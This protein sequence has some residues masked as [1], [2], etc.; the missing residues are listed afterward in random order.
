MTVCSPAHLFK[1]QEFS[2][3]TKW[4]IYNLREIFTYYAN[5][6]QHGIKTTGDSRYNWNKGQFIFY[7]RTTFTLLLWRTFTPFFFLIF[8]GIH[9]WDPAWSD[10]LQRKKPF[11]CARRLLNSSLSL[12]DNLQWLPCTIPI[13]PAQVWYLSILAHLHRPFLNPKV[14]TVILMTCYAHSFS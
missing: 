12:L 2:R 8:C 14:V 10:E 13:N 9:T 4:D 3:L 11:R 1:N 7:L 5:S 6:Y